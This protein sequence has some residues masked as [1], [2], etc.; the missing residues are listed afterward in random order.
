[1]I[2]ALGT[3]LLS[4]VD[5]S[6]TWFLKPVLDGD[7]VI[8]GGKIIEIIDN[9]KARVRARVWLSRDNE[10]VLEGEADIQLSS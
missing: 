4:G 9:E 10:I 1:M 5:A 8:A 3:I 2:G 7:T 6:L